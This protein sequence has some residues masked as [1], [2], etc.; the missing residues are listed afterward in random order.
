LT[1]PVVATLGGTGQTTYAIG[2]ILYASTTSA[3]S[4][5]ADVA[6]GNALISG[7]TNTAPSWGKIGLTTHVTGTLPVANGGTNLTSIGTA[8]Q[9]LGVNTGATGLEY[10]TVTAGTAISVTP[11]AG[12]ITIANTGVTSIAG[13]ANQ[14]TAS[15]ATGAVTLSMPANVT[16]GTS[17]TVSGLSANSFLYSGTAGLL[18]TATP[19]NGQLLIGSTG[20]AP[21]AATL[22]AGTGMSITNGAGSI[23]LNNTGVTSVGLSLPGIF[24]VSGS[25]VTTTGTLTATLASQSANLVFASPNGSAGTPSFRA[26]AYADLPIVLFKENPSSPVALVASGANS[27]A[28]GSGASSTGANAIAH[29]AGSS[30]NVA[31]IVT[32]ANGS[33]ASAG[34]AQSIRVVS[35]NSTTNNTTTELF[36]DGSAQRLV[37]PN[38]SAWTYNIQVVGRRTDATGGYA[39]YNFVGGIVRDAT[40]ATTTIPA[41]SRTTIFETDGAWNCTIS[42]DTTNGS[43]NINVTGQAAKTIRWVATIELTQVTN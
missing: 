37:L 6:T 40:A 34:D 29:G 38:N 22:T 30:S 39:M 35:R 42:A 25:P 17:L 14:I 24:T 15:A 2:D 36:V 21:V 1:S 13:T 8:N 11:A 16:I 7:G 5:L 18:T 31:N 9:I 23:T 33:F 41:S 32:F 19:T 26:L 10:K 27:V 4:R 12:S 20:A 3:L 43:L 28:I